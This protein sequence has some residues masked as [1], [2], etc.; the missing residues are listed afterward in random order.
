[1]Q[2]KRRERWKRGLYIAGILL[3]LAYFLPRIAN[4]YRLW[5]Q[6]RQ[7]MLRLNDELT[8]LRSKNER[9]QREV[10]RLRTPGGMERKAREQDGLR[11]EKNR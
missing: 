7:H 4:I 6:E 9:M 10:D 2:M 3:I 8:E 1:M 11:K 5:Y